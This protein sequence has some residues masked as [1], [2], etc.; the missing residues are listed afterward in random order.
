MVRAVVPLPHHYAVIRMDPEAMLRDLGLDDPVT[1]DE[2]RKIPV[3]K[4]LVYLNWV[5]TCT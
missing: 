4:Y 2:V 1:L 5:R 3:K